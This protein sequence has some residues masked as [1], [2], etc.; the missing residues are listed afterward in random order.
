[1]PP[2]IVLSGLSWV[3]P[4]GT[5]LFSDIS[6][7]FGP[8]RAGIVGRNGCGKSTLLRILARETEPASGTIA[9]EGTV[10]WMRQVTGHQSGSVAQ[11]LG[12]AESLSSTDRLLRG[13]GTAEDAAAADWSLEARLAEALTRVGLGQTDPWQ[14]VDTLSGGQRT[15]LALARILLDA[16][17]ILLLDEPTNNLDAEG[18]ALVAGFLRAWHGCIIV[19]SHDRAL[20]EEVDAIVELANRTASIFG[21][22]W[23]HFSAARSERLAVAQ[24]ALDLAERKVRQ[25]GLAAQMQRERQNRSD[26]RGRAD[27]AKGGAPKM[28]FD[29]REERSDRTAGRG[30]RLAERRQAE[31]AAALAKARAAVEVLAPLRI[32]LPETQRGDVG[33]V[34]SLQAVTFNIGAR[35][36][37]GPLDLMVHRGERVAITGPNGS[38]KSTLLH[39]AAGTLKPTAG[40]VRQTG[41]RV[42]LLDQHVAFLR[43]EETLIEAMRRLNP[44]LSLNESHAA[45]ARSGFRNLTAGKRCD[46]LSGGERMRAGLACVLSAPEPPALLLLDEP[47]NHMDLDS[48]EVLEAGLRGYGGALVVVSHDQA[49]LDEIQVSRDMDLG[50]TRRTQGDRN[51]QAD[52]A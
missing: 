52:H 42:A 16:P 45:L 24:S 25:T 34:L 48:I 8:G 44:S 6:L 9:I 11:A 17:D 19:A 21:G 7:N 41:G 10:G 39:L 3:T 12:I 51:E 20:L 23:S 13:A 46:A 36:V 32:E 30:N 1:M 37:L 38:G 5:P 35:R 47:T 4:D 50:E 14:P 15:R 33:P 2:S 49:F 22:P 28:A 40:S 31:V 27:R 18:R 26:K 43:D 29:A